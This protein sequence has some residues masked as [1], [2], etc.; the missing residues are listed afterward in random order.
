M[1]HYVPRT[2]LILLITFQFYGQILAQKTVVSISGNEFYVNSKPDFPHSDTQKWDE[3]QNNREFVVNL[4]TMNNEN[5]NHLFT[6]LKEATSPLPSVS[7][8]VMIDSVWAAN[9]VNFGLQTVDNQQYVAYFDKNRLM[10][11]ASRKL[12]ESTWTKKTLSSQLYWDSHNY[13]VLALDKAGYIHVSGN[14]HADPLVYFKSSKP[15][16][17]NSLETVPNMTRKDEDRVTYP[18]FFTD[19]NDDLFY[20]YRSGGSGDGTNYVNRYDVQTKKWE[21]Y[22]SEPLFEGRNNGETR[23]S[24]YQYIKDSEGNF[25]YV[26]MWRWT[27]MVET[28]HQLCYATSPDLKNWKNAAGATVQ[29]PLRP[30]DPKLIIDDVPSK[31]GMHNSRHKIIT[32]AQNKP[33]I[34]YVKYDNTGFTQLYI[35][36][37]TGNKWQIK[38]L[39]NWNFRWKFNGSGDKMTIG[40]NFEIKGISKEG[41][42]IIDWETENTESGT[43]IVDLDTME[44]TDK[45][46]TLKFTTP[47]A[48]LS[49]MSNHTDM[50]T[51]LTAG[52]PKSNNENPRY[53]LKWETMPKSHRKSAPPVIPSGPLSPLFLITVTE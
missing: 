38:Q 46:Y 33:V 34:V 2:L 25:H 1:L 27:P 15:F 18:K 43:F 42:L 16:D 8:A 47:P 31:G 11:V 6:K 51:Q 32:D 50:S 48:L 13:V 7:E 4:P 28:C 17:I 24:Y 36:K 53:F 41:F 14:M 19:K 26:W 22:L 21:R 5:D 45:P 35:T 20:A 29:L 37:F 52:N 9:S 49:R 44:L 30:D 3:A 12:G 39:S 40:G 23:S 10:T